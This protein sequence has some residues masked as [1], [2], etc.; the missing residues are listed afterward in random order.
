MKQIEKVIYVDGVIT[1]NTSLKKLV[2]KTMPNTYCHHM[3]IKFGGLDD[4][5]S[6]NG[7]E[8][9][10]VCEKVFFNKS[11]VAVSGYV[12]DPL[13]AKV[14]NSNKQHAHITVCTNQG[15]A[16]VYS[17][18]LLEVGDSIEYHDVVKMKIG[19]FVAF[20]DGSTGW[21]F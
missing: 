7:I 11:A 6:Y 12:N 19:T 1:D 3:T 10:F 20:T 9:E 4:I 21:I 15:V 8:I 17:N 5:P 14:M 2:N 16:P 13:I 18:T